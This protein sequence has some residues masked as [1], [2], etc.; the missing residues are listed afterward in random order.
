MKIEGTRSCAEDSAPIQ[1]LGELDEMGRK[2]RDFLKVVTQKQC[3]FRVM[4]LKYLRSR[5]N[6]K[7]LWTNNVC[8]SMHSLLKGTLEYTAN[9]K[10]GF[11]II[12]AVNFLEKFDTTNAS[13]VTIRT[14][15]DGIQYHERPDWRRSRPKFKN[16]C[17]TRNIVVVSRVPQQENGPLRRRQS[18]EL[19]PPENSYPAVQLSRTKR[20]KFPSLQD[21]NTNWGKHAA[22]SKA[23]WRKHLIFNNFSYWPSILENLFTVIYVVRKFHIP[24]CYSWEIWFPHHPNE[25]RFF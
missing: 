4:V 14:P 19:R 17:L 5:L 2:W 18:K 25:E 16:K 23:T 11:K 3:F 24:P 10:N 21:E 22:Y 15:V 7:G 8:E 6:I 1:M 12:S 9:Q 13:N 20:D